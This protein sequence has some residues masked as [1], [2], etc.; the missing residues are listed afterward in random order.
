[1]ASAPASC[2]WVCVGVEE[3]GLGVPG[4]RWKPQHAGARRPQGRAPPAHRRPPPSR[5]TT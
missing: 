1:M 2:A 4:P 5:S 3:E